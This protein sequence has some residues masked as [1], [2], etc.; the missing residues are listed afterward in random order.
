MGIQNWMLNNRFS[1]SHCWLLIWCSMAVATSIFTLYAVGSSVRGVHFLTE[2][3][4]GNGLGVKPARITNYKFTRTY[5]KTKKKVNEKNR[6]HSEYIIMVASFAFT[7]LWHFRRNCF[8]LAYFWCGSSFWRFWGSCY[9]TGCSLS[10]DFHLQR[11]DQ[12]R[13]GKEKI[14]YRIMPIA[15]GYWVNSRALEW[16]V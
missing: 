5:N 13:T 14:F 8:G 3:C 2:N 11:W 16:T 4:S 15:G 10:N 9:D 6:F 7:D 12:F 1:G